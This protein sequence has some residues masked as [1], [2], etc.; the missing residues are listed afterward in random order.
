MYGTNNNTKEQLNPI[1]NGLSYQLIHSVVHANVSIILEHISV[2]TYS[3]QAT[4][5]E[6][7]LGGILLEEKT[8]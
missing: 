3:N 2:S 6:F 7:I 8:I 1:N 4:V 5:G